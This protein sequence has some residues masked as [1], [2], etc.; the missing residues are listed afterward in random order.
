[1]GRFEAI[2][3]TID[4][5]IR[6]NGNQEIT[7]DIMN[8]VLNEMVSITQEAVTEL[9]ESHITLT[10]EEYDALTEKDNDKYYLIYEEDS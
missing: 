8:R 3:V 2:K 6:R 9:E 4:A 7:G 10:Q 5:N 1:M